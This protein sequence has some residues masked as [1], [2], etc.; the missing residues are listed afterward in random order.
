RIEVERPR[1]GIAAR[2]RQLVFEGIGL[3]F[4]VGQAIRRDKPLEG[5][6]TLAQVA[7]HTG[8]VVR[9]LVE[10]ERLAAHA[11]RPEE[12]FQLRLCPGEY[13]LVPAEDGHDEQR[14]NR[15][16]RFGHQKTRGTNHRVTE[17]TEKKSQKQRTIKQESELFLFF[18]FVLL[19]ALCDSV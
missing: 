5:K 2:G 8:F 3:T 10:N 16:A 12:C 14:G 4:D 7:A 15:R 11:D 17:N 9:R 1:F 13:V 6:K 19:C 18:S